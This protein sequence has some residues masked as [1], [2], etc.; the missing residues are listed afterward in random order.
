[1]AILK[2]GYDINEK[3]L[4]CK[5]IEIKIP[6]KGIYKTMESYFKEQD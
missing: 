2:E 4:K 5:S 3:I 1:M 6:L